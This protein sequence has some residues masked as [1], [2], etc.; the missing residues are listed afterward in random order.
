MKVGMARKFSATR[1]TKIWKIMMIQPVCEIVSPRIRC[2]PFSS[3]CEKKPAIPV[4]STAAMLSY[5]R[6]VSMLPST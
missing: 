1:E 3:T 6:A 4:P 2:V 5:S